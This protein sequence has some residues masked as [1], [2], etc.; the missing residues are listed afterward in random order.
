MGD[1][2]TGE[3]SVLGFLQV[4]RAAGI[5][6]PT[7]RVVDI[8][9]AVVESGVSLYWCVR[10]LAVTSAEQLPTYDEVFCAYFGATIDDPPPQF[11]PSSERSAESETMPPD[12]TADCRETGVVSAHEVDS[13]SDFS[14]LDEAELAQV[15]ALIALVARR[16]FAVRRTRWR[17][18]G[19]GT[20]D[21]A[22]ALRTA[23]RTGTVPE[24]VPMRRKRIRPRPVCVL[25]DC[26][27]S[28]DVYARPWLAFAFALVQALPDGVVRVFCVGTAL[29][30]VTGELRDRDVNAA[31]ARAVRRAD[32]LGS[33][34]RLATCVRELLCRQAGDPGLRAASIVV[35]SD[36]LDSEPPAELAHEMM[37]L[38]RGARRVIWCNPL[39]GDDAY[40]FVQHSV[41][42][43]APFVDRFVSAHHTESVLAVG[44]LVLAEQPS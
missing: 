2:P 13:A 7:S 20:V 16:R 24:R 37:T 39:L 44:D 18:T 5:A 6:V 22:S 17:R 3:P 31:I 40:E 29:T 36:G 4:L 9:R 10:L 8:H 26:S 35:F 1:V 43:A 25:V 27:N 38:R 32:G 23:M 12:E 15:T 30:E 11:R 19:H 34:T 33:G 14:R 28:T 42:A 41:V 21:M